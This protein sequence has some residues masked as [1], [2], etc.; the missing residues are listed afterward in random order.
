MDLETDRV[1]SDRG[2]TEPMRSRGCM[3]GL[4]GY[5][6]SSAKFSYSAQNTVTSTRPTRYRVHSSTVRYDTTLLEFYSLLEY[7]TMPLQYSSTR[8]G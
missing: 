3:R 5:P 7:G 1:D 8:T 4:R 6:R 2:W